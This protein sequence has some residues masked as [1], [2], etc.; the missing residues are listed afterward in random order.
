MVSANQFKLSL[1]ALFP[2]AEQ[3]GNVVRFGVNNTS[4]VQFSASQNIFNRDVLLASRTKNDVRQLTKSQTENTRID[5]VVNVS[6]AFYDVIIAEQQRKVARKNTIR[7]ERSL[8][9]A[10]ARYEAGIVDKTDYKRAT[11]A[12]NNSRRSIESKKSLPEIIDQLPGNLLTQY[13]I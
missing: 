5:V 4:A 11:I 8:K 6:K 3:C 12:L 7:L 10:T 9:D 2:I 1:P 13:C